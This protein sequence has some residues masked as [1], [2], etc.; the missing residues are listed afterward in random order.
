MSQSKKA[1]VIGGA[2]FLGR[3]VVALLC[4]AGRPD[5]P[6]FDEVWV[7]DLKAVDRSTTGGALGD[8][9][10]PKVHDVIGD[11][12]DS[13]ALKAV[14]QDAH[15]VFHLASMVYVG[16]DKEP[17]VE[18]I[19]VEGTRRVIE[20][21]LETQVQVLVYTSSED[22]VLTGKPVRQGDE[23]LPYP[24]RFIHDYVWTKVE[25]ERLAL[26][27]N[28]SESLKT[29]SLRPVHIYGPDDPHALVASLEAFAT[30]TV[31]FLLGDG[32]ARFDIVYVDNV[33]HA[34]LLAAKALDEGQGKS[35]VEGEA[36]FIGENQYPNYFD[37][38]RPYAASK[39]IKMPR[40][41]LPNTL[42]YLI[43]LMMELAHKVSGREVPFHRFHYSVLC[44]DFYFSN[45]KAE[46]LLGYRPIVSKEE[47]EARTMAWL[48]GLEF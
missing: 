15:T 16:L 44:K 36:F 27:A 48:E 38:L 30:G 42:V 10:H 4:G 43:A 6:R 31:P 7:Y 22:V 19:N 23:S 24:S 17:M 39:G 47:A 46:R 41:R 35:G 21:C 34:H 26:A 33:A 29:C 25:G 1:V 8:K 13:N 37:W 12:R 32:K 20:A 3:R 18:E 45:E 5:W 14:C 28:G 11:V 9:K 2:G 40:L